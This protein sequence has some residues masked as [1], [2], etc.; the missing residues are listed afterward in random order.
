MQYGDKKHL[1]MIL[2]LILYHL[3]NEVVIPAEKITEMDGKGPWRVDYLENAHGDLKITLKRL[4]I[5]MKS[6]IKKMVKE[7][8]DNGKDTSVVN[9]LLQGLERLN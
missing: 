6:Q 5:S 9:S 8:E 4:D 1:E 7:M 2:F 3:G